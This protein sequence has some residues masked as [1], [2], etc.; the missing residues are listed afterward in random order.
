MLCEN[1]VFLK[2]FK[3]HLS[4]FLILYL[5]FFSKDFAK[6]CWKGRRPSCFHGSKPIS[7]LYI[8]ILIIKEYPS[9]DTTLK[10]SEQNTVC[11]IFYFRKEYLLI[12]HDFHQTTIQIFSK[13][14]YCGIK[15]QVAEKPASL[16]KGP[17]F[18]NRLAL[19]IPAAG[20]KRNIRLVGS[21]WG[22]AP[23]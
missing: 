8:L 22:E 17:V 18:A 23:K 2:H 10:R 11:I 16:T 7:V 19:T 1:H 13:A 15:Y 12:C 9:E 3:M 21:P 14:E 6:I 4:G 20:V 5:L